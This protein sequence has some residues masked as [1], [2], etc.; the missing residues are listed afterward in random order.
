[1]KGKQFI[2]VIL[3]AVLLAIGV[4]FYFNKGRSQQAGALGGQG[5]MPMPVARCLTQEVVN[6]N[7]FTGNLDAVESVDIRARVQGFL[8]RIAFKDGAFV[9][10]GD[11][12]FEIEPETYQAD[13]DRAFANLKS[14]ES[15]LVRAQ[16]DYDRIMEAVQT[17]AVSQ[18]DASRAKAQYAMAE[19]SVL[20]A[21]A[22]LAQA[23]LNLGYTQ[24]YSPIDG[25]ISRRYVDVGNLVGASDKTLLATIVQIDPL[26]VYFY[27][28]ES[29]Y[30]NYQQNLRKNMAEEPNNLP[31]YISL[32]NDEAYDHQGRLDYMD[33]RVDPGT[34]TIQIRG[35]IPNPQDR[36]YPGMFVK[37]RVPVKA[38]PSALLI[39]EKAIMTDLGG[40]Y[41]LVVGENNVLQRRDIKLGG[42]LDKLRVVTEGLNGDEIF[43]VGGFAM[44]RPGMPITPMPADGPPSGM[45]PG[46]GGQGMP[47]QPSEKQSPAEASR[48]GGE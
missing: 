40:K 25:K 44:A 48:E 15:D 31:V 37:V 20:S 19:A 6:Y 24:I 38:V 43:I 22:A 11:L 9:K 29:E 12:L 18:Q 33:N 21:K 16:Q 28:S 3:I 23:E 41:V 10:K 14:A 42:P 5:P 27:V 35:Q 39:P 26:Y 47:S 13:R 7:E 8:R 2:I 4:H 17:N 1:M 30:L 45:M 46:S 36:L 34:G 32:A